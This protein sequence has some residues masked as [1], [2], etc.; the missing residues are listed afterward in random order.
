MGTAGIADFHEIFFVIGQLRGFLLG[1]KL[2]K[3]IFFKKLNSLLALS[4]VLCYIYAL[5]K[6]KSAFRELE[7][8]FFEE[9]KKLWPVAKGS[10]SKVRKSCIRKGCKACEEGRG[11]PAYVYTYRE[12]GKLRCMHVRPEFAKELERAIENGRLLEAAMV[13]L[14]REAIVRYREDT[15]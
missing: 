3:T 10:V 6:N 13:R 9:L 1:D 8:S 12:D 7:E 11:H 15:K 5:M 14:G 4:Y 2:L